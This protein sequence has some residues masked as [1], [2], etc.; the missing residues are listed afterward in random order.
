[1]RGCVGTYDRMLRVVVGLAALAI[2]LTQAG[3]LDSG[4]AYAADTVGVIGLVTGL[5]GRCPLYGLLGTQTCARS[6]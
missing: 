4:W 5:I 2:G 6:H 3:A 1:M